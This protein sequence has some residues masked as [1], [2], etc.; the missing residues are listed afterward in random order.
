MRKGKNITKHI[1]STSFEMFYL[2]KSL[3]WLCV[4]QIFTVPSLKLGK[5]G[6][7]YTAIIDNLSSVKL[8]KLVG[9][10]LTWN[11]PFV[12]SLLSLFHLTF[13]VTNYKWESKKTFLQKHR[14]QLLLRCFISWNLCI[15]FV[16]ARFSQFLAWSWKS[17]VIFTLLFLT[18]LLL[19]ACHGD[20]ILSSIFCQ[21][22]AQLLVN[23]FCYQN[24]YAQ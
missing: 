6:Y 2:L 10:D 8:T 21:L 22:F 23:D 13:T 9:D 19:V 15:D 17:M 24:G 18:M 5:D 3:Y 16:S 7:F 20:N 12:T 1:K 11:F 4:C 14:N